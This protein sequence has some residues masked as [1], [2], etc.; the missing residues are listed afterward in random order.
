[1]SIQLDIKTTSKLVLACCTLH[2]MIRQENPA[3][4]QAAADREDATHCFVPGFW[5]QG[6]DQLKP[7]AV[8]KG[9]KSTKAALNQRNVLKEYFYSPVG[10][11][12]WHDDHLLYY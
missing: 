6:Q 9:N 1:M 8:E 12:P 2:N 3:E 7:L 4:I 5:R 10:S 11:V